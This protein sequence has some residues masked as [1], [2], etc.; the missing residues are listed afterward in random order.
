MPKSG[1]SSRSMSVRAA[2]ASAMISSSSLVTGMIP[3]R[4]RR[5]NVFGKTMAFCPRPIGRTYERRNSRIRSRLSAVSIAKRISR[6]NLLSKLAETVRSLCSSPCGT[7]RSRPGDA[8]GSFTGSIDGTPLIVWRTCFSARLINCSLLLSVV[9][10]GPLIPSVASISATRTLAASLSRSLRDP[11][12]ATARR[13]FTSLRSMIRFRSVCFSAFGTEAYCLS[14]CSI[15]KFNW[16][17]RKSSESL[18]LYRAMSVVCRLAS[19]RLEISSARI[20]SIRLTS[21]ATL[22]ALPLKPVA[23]RSRNASPKVIVS[24]SRV[25][26]KLPPNRLLLVLAAHSVAASNCFCLSSGVSLNSGKLFTTGSNP[27]TRTCTRSDL[28]GARQKPLGRLSRLAGLLG[29]RS[30]LGSRLTVGAGKSRGAGMFR[31]Q[32]Y[33]NGTRNRLDYPAPRAEL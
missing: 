18:S 31:T 2:T 33:G 19:G 10:A 23:L 27:V 15:F 11:S 7:R 24:A 22:L 1:P 25:D 9:R 20:W 21:F 4:F 29:R 14:S 17:V 26:R 5:S 8:G 3:V 30:S 12:P 6:G 28:D 13:F 32:W 16:R